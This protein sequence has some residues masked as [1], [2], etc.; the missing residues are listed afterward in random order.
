MRV[1]DEQAADEVLVARLHAGAALAAAR[2]APVGRERHAL[3]VAAVRHGHHHVLAGDEVLVVDAVDGIEDLG[4][5]RRAEGGLHRDHLVLDDAEQAHARLQD[6]E[7]VGDL[8]G[9]LVQGFRD[10]LAAERGE[11]LQAQLEDAAGLRFGEPVL[12][13]L[14]ERVA[15]VG[16]EQDQRRHVLGGPGPAHQRLARRRR[17]GRGPDETDHLVD[18]GHGDGEADLQVGGVARLGE[19]ELGAAGDDLLAEV[20]EG[21]QDVA[22]VH[23]LRSAAVQRDHVAA[24]RGLHGGEAPKLVQHHVGDSIALQL[25]DDAHALAV[26]LVAQ[27]GDALDALLADQLGDALDQR[28]LVDLVGDLGDD[29]RLAL[30]AQRLGVH[31]RADDHRA[32]PGGVGGTDAG[33]PENGAAGREIRPRHQLDQLLEAHVRLVDQRQAGVDHLDEVVRRDVGRHADRDA[34]GT[35]DEQ[36]G[37]ACR[38]DGGLVLLAVVVRLEVDGVRVD[39][40]EQRHRRARQAG[41]GVA[42]RRRAIAVDRAEIALPVDQHQPHRERLRHAHQRVVDRRVAVRVVLAHH[43]ADDAR[44]LHIGAIG[45]EVVLVGGEQDATVHRLQPVAHVGQRAADDDAH[46]VVE[47]GAAHLVGDGHGTHVRAGRRRGRVVVG[48]I[49]Q[50][51]ES[52]RYLSLPRPYR[53]R[54]AD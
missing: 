17:V 50:G 25:D 37:E 52:G 36:V 9:E 30:L 38:Q 5:P 45:R 22:Q 3:D 8:G 44:R 49:G 14:V 4:A 42:H 24:E 6:V 48:R 21:H 39:V 11:A 51:S 10:L 47:V 7:I 18:V 2:L 34:A 33:A 46:R 26:G 15:R 13:V 12:A 54:V 32:A 31:L 1:G 23:Q 35:V 41:L 29:E 28:R 43:L 40:L 20:D 27:V 16:D 53:D 19:P